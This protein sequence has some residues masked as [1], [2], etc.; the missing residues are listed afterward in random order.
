MLRAYVGSG[1]KTTAIHNDAETY[2]KEGKTVLVLTS[3]HMK[4]EEDTLC[5][6]CPEEIIRKLKNDRYCMAGVREGNKI[7]ALTKETYD[8]VI[9]HADVVLIE[10]DGSRGFPLK[11]PNATEPVVYDNV[12]EIIVVVGLNALGKPAKDV[13]H[14][15]ETVKDLL[16]IEENTLITAHHIQK[17]LRKGYLYRYPDKK[18]SVLPTHADSL[19]KKAL[20]GLLKEDYDVDSI[21]ED[22]FIPKP[23]LVIFGAGYVAQETA[24]LAVRLDFEVTVIDDREEFANQKRYPKPIQ[25]ICD[26][27]EHVKE[28][29][30]E[31]AYYV[32]VTRG[33][34]HDYEVVR[35]VLTTNYTYLGMIGSK[36]KVQTTFER[37]KGE[38]FTEE[39]VA[40]IHAPIGLP[41][42]AVTPAEIA[43]SILAEIIQ[44]KNER[45]CA[46][47]SSQL[48]H[49][50]KTGTLCIITQKTGSSPRGTGA[51]M[52][53]CEEETID[54][55]GGGAEEAE[56]IRQAKQ[57][58]NVTEITYDLDNR[59]NAQLGMICGGTNTILFIPVK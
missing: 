22:W 16:Q 18:V 49:T 29:L 44:I 13:C 36:K 33:H 5:T 31:N 47:V 53:V 20:A 10:A 11:Y 39:S 32:V 58:H 51:M 3:T 7:T 17:L 15:W 54:T 55:I 27:M 35:Q 6:D 56:I 41:I 4:I 48:L 26:N 30:T 40:T 59:K 43:V 19:Y 28:H 8:A 2:L 46:S 14:R 37:L 25:V 9:S 23:H 42:K 50:D 38:G 45:S 24:L 1:G 52:L 34:Q 21:R 57:I 12:E